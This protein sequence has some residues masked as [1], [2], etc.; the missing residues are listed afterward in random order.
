MADFP[1]GITGGD[2]RDLRENIL[3]RI[4]CQTSR[5]IKHVITVPS[6][7]DRASAGHKLDSGAHDVLGRRIISDIPAWEIVTASTIDGANGKRAGRIIRDDTH[8]TPPVRGSGSGHRIPVEIS[9]AVEQGL[10]RLVFVPR[11]DEH[12]RHC[13]G[14]TA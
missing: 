13:D 4:S 14:R 9:D 3:S 6:E 11:A 12:V 10:V 7:S 1:D 5:L 8:A 2:D